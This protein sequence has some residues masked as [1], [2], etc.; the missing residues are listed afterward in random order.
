MRGR[1]FK[2][3]EEFEEF[4]RR[5]SGQSLDEIEQPEL[6]PA[7]RAQDL[8]FNAW[9]ETNS[10][11]RVELARKALELW[12]DCADAYCVLAE[13]ATRPEE[14]RSF[15]ENAVAAG[16]RALGPEPFEKDI[17][18]FWGIHTTRPYMRARFA[19]AD[20][21]WA[22]S[23][24]KTAIR[25]ARELLRLNA[26]DNLGIRHRL[27]GWLLVA[28]DRR[29]AV[30]LLHRYEE[31]S[32]TWSYA[33]ALLEYRNSGDSERARGELEQAF[34]MNPFVPNYLLLLSE[35]PKS[36]SDRSRKRS[37]EEAVTAIVEL[38]EAWSV[39]PGALEWLQA[40]WLARST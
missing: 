16:E 36:M 40:R 28:D 37:D 5:L 38:F 17:G 31:D 13:E 27:M 24:R 34:S 25:H 32:A 11:R 7:D 2:S 12:P 6:T 8:I 9:E 18:H 4:I 15:Y 29:G 21:L 10:A 20:F 19:L 30:G 39:T 35:G 1:N 3:E 14:Q 23:E 33:N 26:S 22:Q